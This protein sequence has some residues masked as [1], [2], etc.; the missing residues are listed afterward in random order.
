MYLEIEALQYCKGFIIRD[1][2]DDP[3]TKVVQIIDPSLLNEKSHGRNAFSS[4][5]GDPSRKTLIETKQKS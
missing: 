4:L 1:R 2:E 3:T 5:P